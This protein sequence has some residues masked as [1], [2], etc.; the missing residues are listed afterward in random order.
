MSID[1]KALQLG[2]KELFL[3]FETEMAFVHNE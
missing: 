3:K 2:K 1:F